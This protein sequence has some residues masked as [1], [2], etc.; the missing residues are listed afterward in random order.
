[1]RAWYPSK[2]GTMNVLYPLNNSSVTV[3]SVPEPSHCKWTV[4][5]TAGAR[6]EL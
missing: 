3:K 6:L 4:D 2:T 5:K 1:M